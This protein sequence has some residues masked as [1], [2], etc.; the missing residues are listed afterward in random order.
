MMT[1]GIL[2]VVEILTAKDGLTDDF[3]NV[4]H[5]NPDGELWFGA[6]LATGKGGLS[7]L[8]TN[9]WQYLSTDD[10]IP[11]RYITA[12][13]P[14]GDEMLVGTG[15]LDR[16]GLALLIENGGKWTIKKAYHMEDGLPEEKIRYLYSG[17][18]GTLWITTESEGVIVCPSIYSLEQPGLPG[19]RLTKENG[20]SDNEIKVITETD[21]FYWL[22]GRYGLTRIERDAIRDA[23]RQ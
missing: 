8:N 15:H 21:D 5:I 11:H 13:L 3:V 12:I 19:L 10:G 16:G 20:L 22:G 17:T 9:G 23:F 4:I 6:Y 7:I 1:E 18:D 14:V 2:Q